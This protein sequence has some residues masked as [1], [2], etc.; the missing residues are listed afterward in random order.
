MQDVIL[1]S[2]TMYN[3]QQI[4]VFDSQLGPHHC[5]K[6]SSYS[7]QWAHRYDHQSQLP[8]A[9]ESDHEAKHKCRE[10]LDEDRHLVRNGVIDLVD[11]T[12]KEQRNYSA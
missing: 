11:I 1:F 12:A 8:S 7:N 5:H 4:L 2:V 6:P 9:N 3:I 10:P